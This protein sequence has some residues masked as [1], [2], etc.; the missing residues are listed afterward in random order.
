MLEHASLVVGIHVLNLVRII[1]NGNVVHR[2][3]LVVC[4]DVCLG[5]RISV[6]H[7][8][9][10]ALLLLVQRR[11]VIMDV[12]LPACK[13]VIKIVLRI[14]VLQCVGPKEPMHAMQIAA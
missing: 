7:V 13:D 5:V 4:R 8:K 11:R 14:A 3:V 6:P 9:M 10:F 1:A 12:L 2:V